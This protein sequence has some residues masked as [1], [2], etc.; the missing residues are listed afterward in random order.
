MIKILFIT[1]NV[2]K[3]KELQSYLQNYSAGLQSNQ[4]EN[5]NIVLELIK[6][7]MEIHEIQSLNRDEIVIHKIHEA[8][9]KCREQ[10]LSNKIKLDINTWI[11]VE[12]TSLC[13]SKLGGFPGPFIK[14]FLQSMQLKCIGNDF[15]GSDAQ[16]FV[17]LAMGRLIRNQ[18]G[19]MEFS[20]IK[21][22]EGVSNGY[23]LK[24]CGANGFGFDPIFRPVNSDKTNAE[25]NIEEKAKYNPRILAFQKVLD[26]LII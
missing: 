15:W 1:E 14:F 5:R 6:P 24:P 25:M 16:S 17:N 11:L 18:H 4:S 7:D 13:I 20:I 2:N 9:N 3:F 23:I 21:S 19:Y 8:L 26:Y 22:F 12:D 10:L